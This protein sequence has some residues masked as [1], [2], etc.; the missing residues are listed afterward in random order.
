MVIASRTPEGTPNRCPVCGKELK[1]EP[2]KPT[3]DA[4]CPHC[5]HLLWFSAEQ[6]TTLRLE[7]VEV[8]LLC[9]AARF[10][11]ADRR[12]RDAIEALADTTR[13]REAVKRVTTCKSWDEVLL[14]S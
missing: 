14:P 6:P 2:S 7:L 12:T 11:P 9:G 5:G 4:P 10:G 1:L 8:I 3:L 13:L